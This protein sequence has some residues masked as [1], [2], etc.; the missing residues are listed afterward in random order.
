MFVGVCCVCVIWQSWMDSAAESCLHT[1]H[2]SFAGRP[3]G[4]PNSGG[5]KRLY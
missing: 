2:E 4:T 3:P 5:G 1:S